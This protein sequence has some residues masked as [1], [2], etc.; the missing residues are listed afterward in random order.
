MLFIILPLLLL[1]AEPLHAKGDLYYV[2]PNDY[3]KTCPGEPCETLSHNKTCPGEPC[4]TLSHYVTNVSEYFRSDGTFQFISGH[5]LLAHNLEVGGI[6][7]LTLIGDEHFLPGLLD[8]PAPSSQIHCN[9][10]VGFSFYA[11]HKLSIR[12]LL[13]SGCG[14]VFNNGST[15]YLRAALALGDTGNG[16]IFD[17]NI[18]RITVQNSTG[19]GLF[20]DNILGTSF[21]M[22]SNFHFNN[23][24]ESYYGGN[25]R[26]T[27]IECSLLEN[28]TTTLSIESSNFQF[29]ISPHPQRGFGYYGRGTGLAL[30]FSDDSCSNV[31]IHVNH[32]TAYGNIRNYGAIYFYNTYILTNTV[33]VNNSLIMNGKGSIYGGGLNVISSGAEQRRLQVFS[34]LWIMELY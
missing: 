27:Y 2:K 9:G 33:L 26:F 3:N 21:I 24:S 12:N 22:N 25:A 19:Y 32:I 6:Q 17:V 8:L 20:A 18:S 23:G 30:V 7:N 28:S 29:A 11:V 15:P 14:A 13:F 5:H 34:V 31:T 1:L 4:E 16:S 10:S